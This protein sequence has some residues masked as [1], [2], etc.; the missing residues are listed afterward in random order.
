MLRL[1][2]L[3]V[4]AVL[5]LTPAFAQADQ[6]WTDVS[7][8]DSACR[9]KVKGAPD[10]HTRECALQCAGSG[11]GILTADGNYLPF[12][13][14]GNEQALTALKASK[15]TDHLRVTVTG[16]RKG[17]TIAVRSLVLH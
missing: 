12:D 1:I 6:T 8:I 14:S 7:L 2:P 17:S 10:A 13:T 5:A 15:K 3:L 9:L 4:A 16:E 11:Y